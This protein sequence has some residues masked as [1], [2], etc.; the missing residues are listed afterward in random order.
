MLLDKNDP[1]AQAGLTLIQ[2]LFLLLVL[3][4]VGYWV[5]EYLRGALA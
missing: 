2:F 3:G 1:S 5:V 4:I